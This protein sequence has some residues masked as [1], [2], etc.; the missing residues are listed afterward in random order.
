M[1]LIVKVFISNVSCGGFSWSSR[2]SAWSRRGS[3][4]NHRLTLMPSGLIVEKYRCTPESQKFKPVVTEARTGVTDD[5]LGCHL[6]ME[7]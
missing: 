4:W 6:A 3:P 2:D 1:E 7:S 5:T